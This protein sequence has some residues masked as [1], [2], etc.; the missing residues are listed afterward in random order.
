MLRKFPSNSSL[1]K[2]RR[3]HKTMYLYSNFDMIF[4]YKCM[5]AVLLQLNLF[6]YSNRL[7]DYLTWSTG[8]TH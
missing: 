3:Y 1:I 5:L 4:K 2:Q 6:W 8:I 7:N